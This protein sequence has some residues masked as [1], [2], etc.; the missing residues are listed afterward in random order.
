MALIF[1]KNNEFKD[2]LQATFKFLKRMSGRGNS[3]ENR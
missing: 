1:K 3:V 2:C